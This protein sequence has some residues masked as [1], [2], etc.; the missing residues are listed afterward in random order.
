MKNETHI[1]LLAYQSKYNPAS[2]VT[3]KNSTNGS[4][5]TQQQDEYTN[6]NQEDRYLGYGGTMAIGYFKYFLAIGLRKGQARDKRKT[7]SNTKLLSK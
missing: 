7:K 1:L 3:G 2:N 5:H 4:N 6:N